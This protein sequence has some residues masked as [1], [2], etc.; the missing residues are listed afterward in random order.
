MDDFF[1]NSARVDVS[2][3]NE[4]FVGLLNEGDASGRGGSGRRVVFTSSDGEVAFDLMGE[5]GTGKSM[6]AFTG[7]V[8]VAKAK[9][10]ERRMADLGICSGLTGELD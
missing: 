3:A 7:D 9:R 8:G 2:L 4:A 10:S 5:R 6:L 1:V